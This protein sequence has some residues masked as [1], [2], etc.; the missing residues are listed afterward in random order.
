VK[1]I[2]SL[3]LAELCGVSQGTVDRALHGRDGVAAATKQRVLAMAEKHGYV[4]NPATMEI[5]GKRRT[6]VGVLTPAFDSPL[7]MGMAQDVHNAVSTGGYRTFVTFYAGSDQLVKALQEFAARKAAA[8]VVFPDAARIVIPPALASA[9]KV[10]AFMEPMVG[11]NVAFVAPDNFAIGY[12]ATSILHEFGHRNIAMLDWDLDRVTV[13]ERSRGY[14]QAMA[15]FGLP[16]HYLTEPCIAELPTL[17]REHHITGL[18][19]HSDLLCTSA[20][21]CLGDVGIR[22]PEHLSM[23]AGENHPRVDEVFP[24]LSYLR[25]PSAEMAEAVLATLEGR[26]MSVGGPPEPV[27]GRSLRRIA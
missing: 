5:L 11:E 12:R 17:V 4:A 13:R 3:Q 21:R 20:A 6:V 22:V 16:P 15:E 19:C 24:G 25:Y 23:I 10:F 8:V 26:E 2:S 1:V 18:F 9:T 7:L 14:R 27:L